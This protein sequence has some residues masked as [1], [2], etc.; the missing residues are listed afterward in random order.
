MCV[1]CAHAP[2]VPEGSASPAQL[3]HAAGEAGLERGVGGQIL[4]EGETEGR[5]RIRSGNIIV[6]KV[7]GLRLKGFQ[8]PESMKI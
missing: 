6:F 4:R 1:D 5:F 8:N 7:W 3:S 2:R